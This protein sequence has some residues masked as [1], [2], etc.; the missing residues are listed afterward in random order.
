MKPLQGTDTNVL[1]IV[2]PIVN[3]A[4]K[5]VTVE[6]RFS[7]KGNVSLGGNITYTSKIVIGNVQFQLE[8]AGQ[9]VIKQIAIVVPAK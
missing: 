6:V 1:L 2:Q 5:G 7:G 9:M 8:K 3:T 4:A